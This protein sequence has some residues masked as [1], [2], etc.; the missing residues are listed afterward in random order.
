MT[1]ATYVPIPYLELGGAAAPDELMDDLQQLSVEESLH[2][3]AAFTIVLENPYYPG[4]DEDEPWRY[5]DL[6]TIGQTVRIGF[7]SSTTADAEFSE[8]KTDYLIQG[9]ITGIESHFSAESQ[10]P[11]IV[12]G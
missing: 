12:R 9:E 8:P 5:D 2:L 11:I 3:P 10:A 6:L 4:R 1:T 7:Q